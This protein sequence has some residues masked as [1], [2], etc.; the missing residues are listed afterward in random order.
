[1]IGR[2]YVPRWAYAPAVVGLAVVVGPLLALLP[3]VTWATFIEDI[4]E[5]ETLAALM[6]S[7]RSALIA[8]LI[9]VVLGVPLALLIARAPQRMATVLRTIVTLPLVLPP[10]VG[11]V[12]LLAVLGRTGVLGPWLE[13]IGVT[14]PFTPAAVVVAQT[15]VA[16][17]FLVIAV[18]GALRS[19]GTRY[20]HIAAGLGASRTRILTRIT[21][22]LILPGLLAAIVLAFAR[23]VGEFGATALL[24]GNRPVSPRRSPWRSIPR[25]TGWEPPGTRRWRCQCS[26][27]RWR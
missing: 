27:S 5:P 6:L 12:A 1:M 2:E 24:A 15:F 3:R 22:P 16:M 8:V 26:S 4:T 13:S 17:P 23:S 10:L 19:A 7:A 20:E 14:V 9:C 21:L 11:G 18:E 25:S